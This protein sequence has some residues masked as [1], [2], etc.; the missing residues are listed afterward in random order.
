VSPSPHLKMET[1][2]IFY[3]FRIPKNG[4]SPKTSHSEVFN[5]CL[6]GQG[7]VRFRRGLPLNRTEILLERSG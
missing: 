1:D 5:L 2:P 4:K 7:A 3:R 6:L